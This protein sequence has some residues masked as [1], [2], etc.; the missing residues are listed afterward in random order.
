MTGV[1]CLLIYYIIMLSAASSPDTRPSRACS[2]PS[3]TF[4]GCRTDVRRYASP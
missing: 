1:C 3:G 2:D 4:M